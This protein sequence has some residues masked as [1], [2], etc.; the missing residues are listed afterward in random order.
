[1]HNSLLIFT[2]V[3][4]FKSFAGQWIISFSFVLLGPGFPRRELYLYAFSTWLCLFW[5][6]FVICTNMNISYHTLPTSVLCFYLILSMCRHPYSDEKLWGNNTGDQTTT[7]LR[8]SYP[9]LHKIILQ[10]VTFLVSSGM[11]RLIH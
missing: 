6:Y 2:I 3:T 10:S 1:M 9:T 11:Y 4:T 7:L 5:N 8:T